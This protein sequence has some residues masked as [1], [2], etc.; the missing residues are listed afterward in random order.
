M[1]AI[2]DFSCVVPALRGLRFGKFPTQSECDALL[3]S[4]YNIFVDLTCA[5]EFDPPLKGCM[6]GSKLREDTIYLS[7]PIKDR[8]PDAIDRNTFSNTVRVIISFLLRDKPVYVFC[9]GGHGRSAVVAAIV[10]RIMTSGTPEQCLYAINAAHS[11]RK[12]MDAK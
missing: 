9:R 7:C 12:V 2:N 8:T 4:G 6:N 1:A 5:D 10:L 11:T 3:T